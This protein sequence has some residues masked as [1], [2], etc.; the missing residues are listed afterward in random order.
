MKLTI[1]VADETYD[2]LL[3]RSATKTQ[4]GAEIAAAEVVKRFA[5]VPKDDRVLVVLA[6]ERREL[7]KS[8]QTTVENAADLVEKVRRLSSV[9]I[10]DVVRPLTPG[11]SIALKDQASFHGWTPEQWFKNIADQ[12]MEEV[13]GRI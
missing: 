7:E 13:M 2:L 6:P 10:G 5:S 12:V 11:E 8:F 3:T 4:Q 1:V 9:G